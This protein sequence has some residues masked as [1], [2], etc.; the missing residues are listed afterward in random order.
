LEAIPAKIVQVVH[1]IAD[2]NRTAQPR[3]T[4][5][6]RQPRCAP[7]RRT[8]QAGISRWQPSQNACRR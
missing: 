1:V 2:Q 8:E 6:N 5:I 3:S 7:I 4:L